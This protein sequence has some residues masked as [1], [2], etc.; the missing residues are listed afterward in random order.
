MPSGSPLKLLFGCCTV[1]KKTKVVPGSD[2]SLHGQKP[3]NTPSRKAL[4]SQQSERTSPDGASV[5]SN[6]KLEAKDTCNEL[7]GENTVDNCVPRTHHNP[8]YLKISCAASGYN[9]YSSYSSPKN[10]QRITVIRK[11]NESLDLPLTNGHHDLVGNG[12]IP[13][14]KTNNWTGTTDTEEKEKCSDAHIEKSKTGDSGATV[15]EKD[16]NTINQHNAQ[17]STPSAGNISNHTAKPADSTGFDLPVTTTPSSESK[18][19]EKQTPSPGKDAQYYLDLTQK[20][21]DRINALCDVA[22]NDLK[23]NPPEEASGKLRATI[24]KAQLLLTQKFKQF[25]GLCYENMNED[26]SK[27][28]HTT[29]QDL[30]GFWDMVGLQI[31][32]INTMFEEINEMKRNNWKEN[33]KK[34]SAKSPAKPGIGQ[35]PKSSKSKDHHKTTPSTPQSSKAQEFAKAREAA[36]KKLLAAKR[37]GRQRKA[38]QSDQEPEIEIFVPE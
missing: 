26:D 21:E 25:R 37:A 1:S 34:V 7:E 5:K 10:S 18:G 19:N 4:H 8:A 12:E 14:R 15:N 36:R 22:E 13:N 2:A 31:E 6:G 35:R 9:Q 29:C 23:N 38:S 20:E 11:S 17:T 27:P 32:D 28:F 33:N 16:S 30:A 24:G 3:S